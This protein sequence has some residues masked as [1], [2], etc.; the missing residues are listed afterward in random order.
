MVLSY[1]VKWFNRHLKLRTWSYT[2]ATGCT[3]FAENLMW[4]EWWDPPPFPHDIE[5]KVASVFTRKYRFFVLRYW[6][7]YILSKCCALHCKLLE[8]VAAAV[9][10]LFV[11]TDSKPLYLTILICCLLKLVLLS[12]QSSKDKII[13]MIK[14]NNNTFRFHQIL[15]TFQTVISCKKRK[16]KVSLVSGM[17]NTLFHTLHFLTNEKRSFN[18]TLHLSDKK[19]FLL[20]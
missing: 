6:L 17:N 11:I 15:K 19:N 5:L 10:S 1:F 7:H 9:F 3:A 2:V 20:L 13:T 14:R 4:L 18:D 12:Y 8:Y 16:K